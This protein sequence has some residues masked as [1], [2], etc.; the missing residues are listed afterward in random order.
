MRNNDLVSKEGKWKKKFI[1]MEIALLFLFTLILI[2]CSSV[3]NEIRKE[4]VHEIDDLLLRRI[5][6]VMKN[7]DE[8]KFLATKEKYKKN[9]TDELERSQVH[10]EYL[11]NKMKIMGRVKNEIDEG[12]VELDSLLKKFPE[13]KSG[14]KLIST[15]NKY[16]FAYKTF[17]D[18]LDKDL[19]NRINTSI[20][21]NSVVKLESN[22]QLFFD[23]LD[24]SDVEQAQTF[25]E[26]ED[27]L[28][29]DYNSNSKSVDFKGRI[30]NEWF[31]EFKITYDKM[32]EWHRKF[33]EAK[34][35]KNESL[36]RKLRLESFDLI[37][38]IPYEKVQK[39]R[40]EAENIL[41]GHN[42]EIEK[43]EK[44]SAEA[45]REAYQLY[46]IQKT[47]IGEDPNEVW[48][49]IKQLGN[50]MSASHRP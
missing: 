23:A 21:N 30:P 42:P 11:Q 22:Q 17:M 46:F 6:V 24:I 37:L 43:L 18:S 19:K 7:I 13:G 1:P 26:K 41:F 38:K 36:Y 12:C 16:F 4:A 8:D 15:F 44:K 40:A 32:H 28:I 9:Y 49:K 2:S 48:D 25:F 35:Q 29:S 20:L 3:E 50:E 10:S 33:L 45:G 34:K 31:I 27:R 14:H 5:S 47:D 39:F